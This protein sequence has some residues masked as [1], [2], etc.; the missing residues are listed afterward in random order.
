MQEEIERHLRS[1]EGERK[2]CEKRCEVRDMSGKVLLDHQTEPQVEG[3]KL[4]THN[5]HWC[6][7]SL[8]GSVYMY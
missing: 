5:R 1:A 8:A 6:W 4:I 2:G 7:V 3:R